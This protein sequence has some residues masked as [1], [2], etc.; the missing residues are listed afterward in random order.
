MSLFLRTAQDQL[1]T[2]QLPLREFRYKG[3]RVIITVAV[4]AWLGVVSVAKM[5]D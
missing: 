3:I 5:L 1:Q 4:G 2:Q